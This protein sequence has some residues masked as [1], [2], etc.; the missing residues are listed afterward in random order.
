MQKCK[1]CK[2]CIFAKNLR[3]QLCKSIFAKVCAKRLFC[4][5]GFWQALVACAPS[6]GGENDPKKQGKQGVSWLRSCR[7]CVCC[8]F[9]GHRRTTFSTESLRCCRFCSHRN[10]T[11]SDHLGVVV[12]SAAIAAPPFAIQSLWCVVASAA[13]ATPLFAIL[14]V[15]CRFCSHRSTTICDPV[16]WVCC[17]FC[18]HRSTTLWSERRVLLVCFQRVWRFGCILVARPLPRDVLSLSCRHHSSS[19]WY[20]LVV[21]TLFRNRCVA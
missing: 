15:C 19:A 14:W 18:S 1:K 6:G 7:P 20:I 21:R 13:I 16:A 17:R 9:C 10:T 11:F 8:R 5:A 12:A 3:R 4:S 2:K